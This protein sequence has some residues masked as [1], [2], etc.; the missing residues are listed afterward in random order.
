MHDPSFGLFGMLDQGRLEK[1]LKLILI[2]NI[3]PFTSSK[4]ENKMKGYKRFCLPA[5]IAP[6]IK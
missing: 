4:V 3:L 2:I 1:Y 5:R 6:I